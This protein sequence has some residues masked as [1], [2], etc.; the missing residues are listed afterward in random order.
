MKTYTNPNPHKVATWETIVMEREEKEREEKKKYVPYVT[1][2]IA[3]LLGLVLG[4]VHR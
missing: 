3:G 4:V 1:I 2:A